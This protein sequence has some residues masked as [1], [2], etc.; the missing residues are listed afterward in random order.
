MDPD[1]VDATVDRVMPE[2]AIPARLPYGL[3][4]E[5]VQLWRDALDGI[6]DDEA[7]VRAAREELRAVRALADYVT[8]VQRRYAIRM[9]LLGATVRAVAKAAGVSDTYVSRRIKILGLLGRRRKK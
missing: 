7:K 2:P 9:Y 3:D 5:A 4:P 1:E 8:A 6:R